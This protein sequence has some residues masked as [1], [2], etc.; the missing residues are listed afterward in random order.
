VTI[1]RISNQTNWSRP[2]FVDPNLATA[3]FLHKPAI[4]ADNAASSPYFGNVYVCYSDQHSRSQGAALLLFANVATSTGG[5][6]TWTARAVAP[7][8]NFQH[9]AHFGCTVRTDS[10]GVV[11][12]FFN[13]YVFGLP[14]VGTHTIV[15][16]F[17]DG[18]TW[19]RREILDVNN[20]CFVRDALA[21]FAC[22]MDGFLG[23]RTDVT[24]APSV[25]IANGAPTG[26]DATDELVNV[27]SDGRFGLNHEVSL[28]SY[29]TDGGDTWSS[30]D[31][32]SVTGDRSLF[33][34]AIA[35]DGSHLY[36]VYMG[37][38]QPFQPTTANPRPVH[39]VLVSSPVKVDGAAYAW[40]TV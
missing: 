32:V 7:L 31:V 26:K 24:S 2:Y 38:T 9:G 19:T 4:W 22:V 17:D 33:S 20:A 28:L 34:A 8:E 21:P 12:A 36:V 11:Y 27:W 1:E 10:H 25:D 40:S 39:G 14:G 29:S 13:H 3:A 16:S 18:H 5:G 15:K 30:P 37:L 23:N 35:P 6:V